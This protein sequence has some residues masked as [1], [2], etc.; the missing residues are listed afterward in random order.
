M[1]IGKKSKSGDN[2]KKDSVKRYIGYVKNT[3][4]NVHCLTNVVTMQDV[5]N[6]LLAAGGSAIMA[7]DIK[8]VEEITQISSATLIN[9]GVPSDEKIQACVVAGKRA[10]EFGHPVIFD[11]LRTVRNDT[12]VYALVQSGVAVISA[13]TNLDKAFPYGVNH[14]LADALGLQNIHGLLWIR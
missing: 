11:P 2:V 7:Q 10:N 8:E 3:S 6:M 13:H 1:I 9:M 12:V 4:P 14:A 5:A